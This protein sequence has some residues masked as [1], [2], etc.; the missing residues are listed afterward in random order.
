MIFAEQKSKL[1]SIF[2]AEKLWAM[3]YTGARVKMAVF[4]TGVRADH[5]H[6]R[7]IMV[8]NQQPI[9]CRSV[10][11]NFAS[12]FLGICS[13]KWLIPLSVTVYQERTD[14][15]NDG[16]LNDNLGHGTFVAGVISSQDPQCLGFAPDVEIYAFRVF[17]DQQV[18]SL[19]WCVHICRIVIRMSHERAQL[20]FWTSV[21][22]AGVIYIVVLR[23]FQLRDCD[24]YECS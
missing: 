15:T 24:G 7:N 23:C 16:N 17:T 9:S 6:F 3:G 1:T 14:W 21:G 22:C 12:A 2:G 8:G 18:W 19:Q 20:C 4:D 5:P 13:M 10:L 11:S